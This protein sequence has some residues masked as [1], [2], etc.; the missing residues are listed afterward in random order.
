MANLTVAAKVCTL[1]LVALLAGCA[2]N[3]LAPPPEQFV[4]SDAPS[5]SVQGLP[6]HDGRGELLLQSRSHDDGFIVGEQQ[7]DLPSL[8]FVRARLSQEFASHEKRQL[9]D[10]C[11][12]GRPLTLARFEIVVNKDAPQTFSDSRY[13]AVPPGQAL[14][15]LGLDTLNAEFNRRKYVHASVSIQVGSETF[16]GSGGG[17][18]STAPTSL[19]L[20]QP[21]IDAVQHVVREIADQAARV[22]AAEKRSQK[23]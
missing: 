19:A 18:Y 11:I 7:L 17:S 20:R 12:G 3:R 15:L 4:L 2:A 14:F 21:A 10:E 5:T 13:N 6:L 8:V 22:R 1:T 16:S 23:Q 9:L